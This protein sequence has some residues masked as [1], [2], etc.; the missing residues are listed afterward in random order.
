MTVL[1]PRKDAARRLGVSV[2]TLKRILARGDLGQHRIG[3]SLKV[4]EDELERFIR[5]AREVAAPR[6]PQRPP[7]PRKPLRVPDFESIRR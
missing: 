5:G 7:R 4:A 1:L 3:G 2:R 6:T